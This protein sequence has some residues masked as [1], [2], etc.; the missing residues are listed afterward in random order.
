MNRWPTLTDFLD[1][2]GDL[3][4]GWP[5]KNRSNLLEELYTEAS[6]LPPAARERKILVER[7]WAEES[8]EHAQYRYP[9]GLTEE[10]H[11]LH[12]RQADWYAEI[13]ADASLAKRVVDLLTPEERTKGERDADAFRRPRPLRVAMPEGDFWHCYSCGQAFDPDTT[14]AIIVGFHPDGDEDETTSYEIEYCRDCIATALAAYDA[15]K[16]S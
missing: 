3:A 2:G 13:L 9:A 14:E 7:Q 5:G 12:C 1:A 8:F 4:V 6:I 10:K 16:V 11:F 15:G